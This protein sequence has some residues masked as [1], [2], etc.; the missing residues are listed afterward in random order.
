[1][2][3]YRYGVACIDFA[4]Q[5]RDYQTVRA[6]TESGLPRVAGRA[7]PRKLLWGAELRGA[8][9]TSQAIYY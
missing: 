1:M 7:A 5:L 9:V 2:D 6:G 3:S 8:A 4:K